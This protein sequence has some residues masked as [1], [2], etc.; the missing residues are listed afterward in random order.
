M[1]I[2]NYPAGS[3]LTI[4]NTIYLYPT[5]DK[6]N[7]KWSKDKLLI[8][9]KDNTTG[10]KKYEEIESP[11][12]EFYIAKK[13]EYIDHNM[14]FIEKDRV[15]K[16]STP[17]N[18][19]QKT[20]AKLTGNL[21]FYN[22]NIRN[23]NRYTNTMLFMHPRIFM[24][25]QHIEDHYRF[26]FSNTYKNSII[27]ITKAYFDIEVDTIHMKGDFPKMGECPINAITIVNDV[28]KTSYT[29][30]LRNKDNPLIQEF[31][32]SLKDGKIFTELKDFIKKNVG[33]WKNEKRFG[34]DEFNYEFMFYDEEIKLI[35]DM[36]ILFNVTKPDFI[37]VW[38]MAFDMPYIIERIKELGYNPEDIICH[39]D[40]KTKVAKYYKDFINENEFAKRGDMVI[41]SSYSVY[42]DQMIHFASRRKGQHAFPDYKLDT[43]GS[44]IA[45]VH[46]LD[47]SSITTNISKLPYLDYKTF[48]FYNIMDT[49]VQ[50]CIETKVGDIDYVFNKCLINNT[51]YNKCH[52]QTIYLVNRGIKEFYNDGYI[53]GC[54]SNKFNEKG[55]KYPGAFVADPSKIDDY[56]KKKIAGNAI[57][58]MDNLDDYDY[59]SLYPSIMREFNIAPNTQIGLVNIPNKVHDG[60]NRFNKDIYRRGAAF[61][62]DLQSHVWLEFCTRWFHFADYATLYKD[63]IEYFT[64]IANPARALKWYNKNDQ[65]IIVRFINEGFKQKV[66]SFNEY[67]KQRIV[68]FNYKA[69]FSIINEH[70]KGGIQ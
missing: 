50:K 47:Y 61:I 53:M 51:R 32:D 54:N 52:R 19:L 69:D 10:E 26:R 7:G 24:A 12:Y 62:E 41:I 38:N 49:I 67:D 64:N 22:D 35:Q 25:D 3:D 2:K 30:L 20:I 39:P 45:G 9:F 59:K 40:F 6:K 17:Y 23:G 33:G 5:K 34:L 55:D 4:L 60:E 66:I 63:I 13:D 1:M 14:L 31:E 65:Q 58:I 18:S 42:L 57:N 28:T 11:E 36:F 21:D 43:I 44:L 48:V 16:I 8:I 29:L 56:A 15:E 37:L 70:F 68:D 27:P 46:K